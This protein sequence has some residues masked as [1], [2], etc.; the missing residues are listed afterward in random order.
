MC[1]VAAL[2]AVRCKLSLVQQE[3]DDLRMELHYSAAEA[4]Q[5]L[6]DEERRAREELQGAEACILQWGQAEAEAVETAVTTVEAVTTVATVA[7]VE[8][9]TGRVE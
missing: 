6:E 8:A 4:V 9:E 3:A 1:A 2:R 5:K 7:T